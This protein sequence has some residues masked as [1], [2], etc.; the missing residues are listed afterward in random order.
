M[1][2]MVKPWQMLAVI[3][4][5]LLNEQQQLAI[6]YLRE[7]NRILREQ[8]GKRRL[9]FTDKQRRRLAVRAK[10]LGRRTL[11]E[12]CC[13]LTPVPSKYSIHWTLLRK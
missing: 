1:N 8:F 13:I 9:R 5:G 7:E 12:V 6:E 3:V 4:A 11:R 10:R 2:Q